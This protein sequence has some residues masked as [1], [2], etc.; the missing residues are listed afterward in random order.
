M[1]QSS[2]CNSTIS[3]EA[4]SN[5]KIWNRVNEPITTISVYVRLF[6]DKNFCNWE[7]YLYIWKSKTDIF[8][9]C[10]L[11]LFV[12]MFYFRFWN[13][14]VWDLKREQSWF[15]PKKAN[16]HFFEAIH[17]TIEYML[18]NNTIDYFNLQNIWF[19]KTLKISL[20]TLHSV[21]SKHS[22]EFWLSFSRFG[23]VLTAFP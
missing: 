23:W 6:L 16:A 22:R 5:V 9:K 12:A 3:C 8:T 18:L 14:Y 15:C 1:V 20:E 13:N 19:L 2:F 11:N 17:Y 10:F 21:L 4:V 7:M